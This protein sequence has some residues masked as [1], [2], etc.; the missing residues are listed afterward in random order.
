M[1]REK[2]QVAP[3]IIAYREPLGVRFVTIYGLVHGE[4]TILV[5]AGLPGSVTHWLDA[6]Q[7]AEPIH[8]VII[9]HA[10]ADHI[11][12]TA[13]VQKRF[14]EAEI[15]CHEADKRWIED[16]HTILQERYGFSHHRYG[17]GYPEEVM[18]A[19]KDLCGPDVTVTRTL[20]DGEILQI[21]DRDWE[22][23][24]VPGHSPG[25]ISLWSAEDGTLVLG[26]AVL[27]FGPPNV[28]TNQASMPATHHI[29]E[30][31]FQTIERFKTL[32]VKLAL[33][34]HW[35]PM[36]DEAFSAFLARSRERV[37]Q[38]IA[39]VKEATSTTPKTFEELLRGINERFREWDPVED[40]NYVF[41]LDGAVQYLL[42]QGE[43][44]YEG[45]R[46]R[47]A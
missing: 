17:I 8:Q 43:L 31:Y 22:V 25:H 13:G 33:A 32:P 14:P 40:V 9:T 18:A 24:H 23:L 39:Y 2:V 38:D 5:D 3:G 29:L 46:F 7:I 41:A 6:G 35:E 11:G 47:A 44:H 12:D 1:E 20:A 26:D 37:E 36:D 19:L 34:A 27:G 10:D 21:G 30:D 15:A 42:A 45:D 16:R 28:S 4:G